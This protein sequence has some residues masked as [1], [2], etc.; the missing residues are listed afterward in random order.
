MSGSRVVLEAAM[1][2]VVPS[3]SWEES[4]LPLSWKSQLARLAS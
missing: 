2:V 1:V 3:S 4:L